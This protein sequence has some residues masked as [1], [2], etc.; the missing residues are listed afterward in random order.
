MKRFL[1]RAEPWLFVFACA[2]AGGTSAPAR[3]HF[4]LLKPDSWLNEDGVG[5]PQKGGPCGPGGGDDV[6]PVPMSGK[7]T[8]FHSGDT[9]DVQWQTTVPHTGF[10][11]ITLVKDR[12]ELKDPDLNFDSSCNFTTPLKNPPDL[13]ILAD[14]INY[15]ATSQQV[16]IPD[17]L[18]C[19]KC[20][21]QV[22]MWMT[23]HPPS[24]VYHHCADLKIVPKG[25][26]AGT[27]GTASGAAGA[28][29]TAGKAAGTGG[30]A[31]GGPVSGTGGAST[32]SGGG[33]QPGATAGAGG[34]VGSGG[35]GT[36][37]NA[38]DIKLVQ[39]KSGGC[40]VAH[41]S[42]AGSFAVLAFVGAALGRRRHRRRQF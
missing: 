6:Q 27:A 13:P 40:S 20:T 4:K 28:G 18:T 42:P 36:T 12:S 17:D 2:A 38:N 19:D 1:T 37:G 14:N 29:G 30:V 33:G 15:S 23:A 31:G 8:T 35:A 41:G 9:I 34:S 25:V 24:C 10:F 22:I 39:K 3:A 11:R 5:G 16:K 7:V 32:T 21:L 26:D